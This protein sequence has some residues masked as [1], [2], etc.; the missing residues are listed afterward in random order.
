MFD[1]D[2]S[3]DL[4]IECMEKV[5]DSDSFL[6]LSNK[7]DFLQEASNLY[8]K[9][10]KEVVFSLIKGLDNDSHKEIYCGQ[11]VCYPTNTMNL[12][13]K[14]DKM[15]DRMKHLYGK[16]DGSISYCFVDEICDNAKS[17]EVMY[18]TLEEALKGNKSFFGKLKNK[19]IRR[20]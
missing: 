9:G 17:I 16:I 19:F 1:S 7:L 2:K 11:A 10:E 18:L 6:E 20:K 13:T 5:F 15:I 3:K 8:E 14:P 12:I 4:F